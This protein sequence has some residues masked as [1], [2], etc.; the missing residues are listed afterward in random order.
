MNEYDEQK[1][2]PG[3]IAAAAS[4]QEKQYV[5]LSKDESI[6]R[7]AA[8]NKSYNERNLDAI[9]QLQK[10]RNLLLQELNNGKEQSR[11]MANKNRQLNFMVNTLLDLCNKFK[12]L[13]DSLDSERF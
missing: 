9:Q 5:S 10:E 2:Q 7:Q 8:V 1:R 6:E 11:L 12:E 13:S 4:N 3:S